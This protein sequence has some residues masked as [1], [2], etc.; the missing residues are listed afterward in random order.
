MCN[1]AGHVALEAIF[2]DSLRGFD[3]R[4]ASLANCILVWGANPSS[5]APHANQYWLPEAKAKKIVIDPI[6]HPTAERADLHLQLRPGTDA[7]LAFALLHVLQRELCVDQRFIE[8]NVVGWDGVEAQL[9]H[10]TPEW[11][12]QAT[13]VP[14]DL[15]VAAARLYGAGPSLLWLGQGLQR[16]LTGGNVFRAGSLLPIVT[17][18]IGKPG[19]GFLYIDWIPISRN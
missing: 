15:I 14:R 6:R 10:C 1:K 17:G 9:A 8:D 12:E 5:S 4:T 7:A 19:G 16:Q 3:P 11:G 2:G 18:M 13:G